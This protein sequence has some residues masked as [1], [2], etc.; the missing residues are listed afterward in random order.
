MFSSSGFGSEQ[1]GKALHKQWLF[2]VRLI[3]VMV[4]AAA[5]AWIMF[6]LGWVISLLLF[7]VL[8]VYIFYP[9]RQYLKR[10]FNLGHGLSSFAVFILFIFICAI[11]V[12]VLIPVI[13]NEISEL[14]EAFPHYQAR[15]QE[16][17]SWLSRQLVMLDVE[18]DVRR[19]IFNLS[20][21]LYGAIEY[22]AEAS[23]ALI[24]GAVDLFLVLFIFFYLLYDFDE[25]R[26][27][28]VALF[29][30][31][32][33]ALGREILEI[34]DQNVGT[35]LRG[36]LVRCTIVGILTTLVLLLIG[37]PYAIL[38]GLIAGLFNFILYIGPY[39]AAVPALLL[40]LSPLTPSPFLIIV[41]Y[42]SL[43]LID[44]M[45]V[46]PLV[47]GRSLKLRAI[48]IIVAILAGGRLAGILGMV[49]AVPVAGITRDILEIIKRGPAYEEP[50]PRSAD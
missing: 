29:P 3:G 36:S 5:A 43:Q 42:V 35:F 48:T 46:A 14:A 31:R 28:F 47:L 41:V 26:T 15:L 1:G 45:F 49:L 40:S 4:L 8:L 11:F 27:Q 33:R 6:S 21:N 7:S 18:D 38:L 2:S 44:G 32:K 37:M 17:L 24:F 30:V 39:I 13:Y 20:E 22:L 10:R 23:L 19:Y 50:L 34:V 9:V 25:I 12:G 16:H